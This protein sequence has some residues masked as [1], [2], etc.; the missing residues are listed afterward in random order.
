MDLMYSENLIK[1]PNF[2]EVPNL[3]GR[4]NLVQID[5]SICLLGKHVFLMLKNCN[6][7]RSKPK[8]MSGLSSLKYLNFSGCCKAFNDPKH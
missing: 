8:N 2:G 7:L 3:E 6:N 5:P 4:V 1:M